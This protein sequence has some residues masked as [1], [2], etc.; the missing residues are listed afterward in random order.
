MRMLSNL[1][2]FSITFLITLIFSTGEVFAQNLEIDVEQ[3]QQR[4]QEINAGTVEPEVVVAFKTHNGNWLKAD[5][6]GSGILSAEAKEI[7]DWEKWE[8]FGIADGLYCIRA[9]LNK[10]YL[11][12]ENGGGGDLYANR[13]KVS[14]WELF[15]FA[16]PS[17]VNLYAPNDGD[18]IIILSYSTHLLSAEEGGGGKVK[19]NRTSV[20]GWE[21]FKIQYLEKLEGDEKLI[22]DMERK[23]T[24]GHVVSFGTGKTEE[25]AIQLA[26]ETAL[27]S[28]ILSLKNSAQSFDKL[29]E[30]LKLFIKD[31]SIDYKLLKKLEISNESTYVFV[32]FIIPKNELRAAFN[33]KVEEFDNTGMFGD[34]VSDDITDDYDLLEYITFMNFFKSIRSSNYFDSFYD[35]KFTFEKPIKSESY[36]YSLKNFSYVITNNVVFNLNNK[37]DQFLD[38]LLSLVEIQA[39][40]IVKNTSI[41]NRVLG[42]GNKQIGSYNDNLILFPENGGVK[43]NN[44]IAFLDRNRSKIGYKFYGDNIIDG[45]GYGYAYGAPTISL[46][47]VTVFK[48]KSK[49][50]ISLINEFIKEKLLNI[51]FETSILFNDGGEEKFTDM[52]DLDYNYEDKELKS[53]MDIRDD[54]TKRVYGDEFLTEPNEYIKIAISP[55]SLTQI[56]HKYDKMAKR[57]YDLVIPLEYITIKDMSSVSEK[58]EKNDSHKTILAMI[59]ENYNHTAT[60]NPNEMVYERDSYG[61]I[62]SVSTRESK[63][64]RTNREK[65]KYVHVRGEYF[66]NKSYLSKIKSIDVRGLTSSEIKDQLQA[67]KEEKRRKETA[68]ETNRGTVRHSPGC[69]QSEARS[70]AVNRINSTIG[71]TQFLDLS[72]SGQNKW[73]FYGSAYSS[74]YGRDVTVFVLIG[75]SGGSYSVESVD[76]Q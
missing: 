14:R 47:A 55:R 41:K 53:S 60:Y 10:K 32:S 15:M 58:N 36:N 61:R 56:S 25:E 11:S 73:L 7:G 52:F 39:D 12:A 3:A 16:E 67:L 42:S 68:S 69:T 30:K 59:S 2:F 48:L 54:K 66:L 27:K 24:E 64:K 9:H 71:N 6:G 70:F 45:I 22:I 19:A 43:D 23:N 1:F 57:I 72:Q 20:G 33:L 74:Q 21:T 37:Y 50:S 17:T 34:I 4:L 65:L 8:L 18:E 49:N 44:L 26:T 31:N 63:Y 40:E 46:K 76:I 29:E 38:L 28:M 51:G 13:D 35:V 62:S 5:L 75:C